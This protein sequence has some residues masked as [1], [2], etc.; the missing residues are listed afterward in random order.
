LFS[1]RNWRDGI[2]EQIREVMFLQG[3]LSI[4]RM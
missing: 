1:R 4:E 2:Y 3:R